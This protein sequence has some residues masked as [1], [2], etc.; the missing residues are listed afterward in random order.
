MP[1]VQIQVASSMHC[2]TGRTDQSRAS[3]QTWKLRE[4]A[5]WGRRPLDIQTLR[6]PPFLSHVTVGWY[7]CLRRSQ[8]ALLLRDL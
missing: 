8:E 5:S 6:V 1:A 2:C 4:V 3:L 7:W